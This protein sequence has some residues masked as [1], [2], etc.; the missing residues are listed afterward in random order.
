MRLRARSLP[1]DVWWTEFYEPLEIKINQISEK[2]KEDQKAL[3]KLRKYQN[4]INMVKRNP[5][6]YASAFFI[7]Q[8]LCTHKGMGGYVK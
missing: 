8:K 2:C 6:R 7:I 3:E 1:E 5:E 4:E